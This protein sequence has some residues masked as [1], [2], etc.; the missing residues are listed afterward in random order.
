MN[1]LQTRLEVLVTAMRLE[2]KDIVSV[3]LRPVGKKNLPPFSAGSH[4]LVELSAGLSRSYS[5]TNASHER[6]RYV[7]AIHRDRASR[8]G[9][10]YVHDTLRVG[11]TITI[12]E[13]RNHFEL[14]ESAEQSVLIAGGIGITPIWCMI[15][16]LEEL[17]G[18]WTLYYA[19]RS[20]C[21]AAYCV[22]LEALEAR[23]PGRVHFHFDDEHGSK[24]FDMLSAL[25][26][27]PASA[28]LYCC[29]PRAMLRAFRES[30]EGRSASRVHVEYFN[31][32]DLATGA[33]S[34]FTVILARSGKKVRVKTDVT[35][36]DALLEE[37]LDVSYSC[38]EGIC[39]TCEVRLL[40]GVADH[41]DAILSD[42]EKNSNKTIII[43]CS[44]AQ[45][46]ELVLDL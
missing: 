37:G 24:P 7:L 15:Q 38:R 31:N 21:F 44:R 18:R 3:E 6:H 23:Q 19:T 29:G 5:L 39:G 11:D 28:D 10:R 17:G 12:S 46:D 26:G 30:T 9:S 25:G 45:S 4:V 8:G 33:T 42:A 20:R 43:C 36:L 22:E 16:R 40:S 34:G 13:P 14:N 2:A 1:R 27:A 32:D 41:R 35:I